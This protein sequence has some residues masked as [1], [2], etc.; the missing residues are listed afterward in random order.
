MQGGMP[1]RAVSPPRQ[2]P[3]QARCPGLGVCLRG[4]FAV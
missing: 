2:R 3:R 1:G 4:G